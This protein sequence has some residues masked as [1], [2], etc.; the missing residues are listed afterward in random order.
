MSKNNTHFIP[1]YKDKDGGWLEKDYQQFTI[2]GRIPSKKNSRIIVCRGKYPLSLPS[3]KYTEWHKDAGEQLIKQVIDPIHIVEE[4]KITLTLFAP[5]KRKADLTN[6]AESV[7]DLL[8]DYGIIE[9]DNWFV[10]GSLQLVFGG[11]DRENPRV[12]III[13]E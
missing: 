7:M 4:C 11:V 8:V 6:K 2:K 5:D 9:D 13:N 12:E 10:V 3:K 1:V